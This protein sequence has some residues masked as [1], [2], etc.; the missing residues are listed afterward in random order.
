MGDPHILTMDGFGY[1]FNGLGEYILITSA[2]L[3]IQGRTSQ[4]MKNGTDQ[5]ATFF[6]SIVGMRTGSVPLEFR[7]NN[8]TDGIGELIDNTSTWVKRATYS[9]Q[10]DFINRAKEQVAQLSE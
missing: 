5:P 2:E 6:S 4:I 10:L 7:L 8:L 3:V 9:E 1:T